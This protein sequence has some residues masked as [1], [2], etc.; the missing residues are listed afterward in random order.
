MLDVDC[1]VKYLHSFG[2]VNESTTATS[3][4]TRLGTRVY[5][6]PRLQSE[7]VSEAGIDRAANAKSCPD[8][9]TMIL[10]SG[11]RIPGT[12]GLEQVSPKLLAETPEQKPAHQGRS[13]AQ[14][15][16][17]PRRGGGLRSSDRPP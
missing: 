16:H 13:A 5:I 8:L 12:G 15:Q 2:I 10:N 1:G 7:M 14:V 6:A 3:G 9:E 11:R 17:Q 4:Y